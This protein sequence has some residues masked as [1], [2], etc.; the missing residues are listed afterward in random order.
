VKNQDGN[1]GKVTTI[2][3]K[4][5]WWCA[6]VVYDNEAWPSDKDADT[7]YGWDSLLPKKKRTRAIP[8]GIALV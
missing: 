7:A 1:G 4:P 8:T 3:G 5:I 2:R 6:S